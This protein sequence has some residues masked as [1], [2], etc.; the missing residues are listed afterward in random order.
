M[1]SGIPAVAK[2]IVVSSFEEADAK[3]PAVFD[4]IKSFCIK[5]NLQ[6]VGPMFFVDLG[7]EM[8]DIPIPPGKMAMRLAYPVKKPLAK[9]EEGFF[10]F[11]SP[12][13]PHIKGEYTGPYSGIPA[14]LAKIKAFAK[15][16]GFQADVGA[17]E[18]Y[19]NDPRTTPE[20]K[21]KTV[22]YYPAVKPD[23][24]NRKSKEETNTVNSALEQVSKPAS[25][26]KKK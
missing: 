17:Y 1:P 20:S 8:E 11:E 4:E 12:S 15:E 18:F 22:L 19:L 25:S 7:P 10:P 23:E 13:G 24:P 5:K 2:T 6:I 9:A 3:G 14:F 26:N 16:N 21:L